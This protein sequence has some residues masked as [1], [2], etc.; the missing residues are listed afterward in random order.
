MDNH[1]QAMPQSS[2]FRLHQLEVYNWG[3]FD[4]SQGQVHSVVPRGRTSLLVGQNGSGKSTL[5]D[6]LLTLLVPSG[7]RNYNVAAGAKKSE[8]GERSYVRGAYGRNGDGDAANLVKYLRPGTAHYSALLAVF[9]DETLNQSFT[10]CQVFHQTSDGGIEKTFAMASEARSLAADLSG[11]ERSDE[12]RGRLRQHGYRTTKKYVEYEAWIARKTGMRAKAMDMFNQT[13]AVKDIHSLNDFLRRHM[14]ESHDW[15]DKVQ[16]L[17]SHFND[18][19]SAHRELSRVQQ[20]HDL[21][22]PIERLGASYQ[23]H[24]AELA[25]A[26]QRLAASEAY[27]RKQTERLFEPELAQGRKRFAEVLQNKSR[28]AD[29]MQQL[30]DSLRQLQNALEDS[31]GERSRTLPILIAREQ[32]IL[33]AKQHEFRRFHNALQSWGSREVANNESQFALLRNQVADEF[34]ARRQAYQDALKQQA[35]M[36]ASLAALDADLDQQQQE[37]AQLA[38]RTGNLPASL[39]TVRQRLCEDLQIAE[40]ELPFAAELIALDPAEQRWQPAIELVL[41]GFALSMLVNE[42]HYRQVRSYVEQVALVDAR[43][44]GQKLVYLRVPVPAVRDNSVEQARPHAAQSLVN[45]LTF[46]PTHTLADWVRQEITRRFDFRCCESLEEFDQTPRFAL[47][48]NR[49]LKTTANHHE[50]DDRPRA[51]DPRNFVLGWD[52]SEKQAELTRRTAELRRQRQQIVSQLEASESQLE[53]YRRQFDA[54]QQIEA[55]HDFSALDVNRHAA[56][57]HAL[58]QEQ[59][60]EANP[61]KLAK[62]QQ[63][64]LAS[65]QSQLESRQRERDEQ[66]MLEAELKQSIRACENLLGNVA[67]AAADDPAAIPVDAEIEKQLDAHFSSQPL[68]SENLFAQEQAFQKQTNLELNRLRGKLAPLT[69]QL[70]TLMGRYL[71]E[72]PEQQA[73]LDA[74][75]D[76][77]PSF[78]GKL[79]E[80]RQEDLPRHQQRFKNRLNEKIGQEVALFSGALRAEAKQ[81]EDKLQQLNQALA[82]LEYRPGT[83]MR[84]EAQPVADREI[85]DFQSQL[86]QCLKESPRDSDEVREAR[87]QQIERLVSR[88]ADSERSRWRD[89]VIDVR[90]WFDFVACEVDLASGETLS[91]YRD[92]SGQSG[93]EKA[94]LAFTILVAAIAYQYDLDPREPLPGKFQFVCVDEMFSKVDDAYAEYALRL[95]DQFGLQLLIVA[96]LDAK[97]RITEPFVDCYLHVVK[98]ADSSRSQIFSMTA[99]EYATVAAGFVDGD[100]QSPAASSGRRTRKPK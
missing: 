80:I 74:R 96:P 41:R 73:D 81:I 22:L 13:V 23:Q 21:L 24:A 15:R 5:V 97:A 83:C 6:A 3:T 82:E 32:A 63:A 19:A 77:L 20:A 18:L 72:F 27:F 76:A 42:S 45:K 11:I 88:L 38:A 39:V 98:D 12:V 35:K 25:N 36:T 90:R 26:Q 10:L 57:L 53:E 92:S 50:K 78:L 30:R 14:L 51:V 86:R 44:V 93:G 75:S 48:V 46:H 29:E 64:R 8:R 95:F 84:L 49:Q 54:A 70:V 31:G 85:N 99:R 87:Y 89:K 65:L 100:A 58:E 47:T 66:V 17:L 34:P 79:T 43:G 56:E 37:I 59:A 71:R 4:S 9:T 55:M 62:T 7:I 2:G 28:L 1:Y 40:S 69:E 61:K 68:T 91:S 33:H 67:R 60:A 52:S 94:K 16:R